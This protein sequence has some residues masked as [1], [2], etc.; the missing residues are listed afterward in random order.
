MEDAPK[1]TE[2]ENIVEFVRDKHVKYLHNLD[3]TKDAEA[4]GFY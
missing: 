3:K 1:Q 2:G 4:I